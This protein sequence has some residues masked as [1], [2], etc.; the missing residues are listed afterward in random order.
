MSSDKPSVTHEEYE[1]LTKITQLVARQAEH[2]ASVKALREDISTIEH[3]VVPMLTSAA[4]SLNPGFLVQVTSTSKDAMDLG[5][6]FSLVSSKIP[7]DCNETEVTWHLKHSVLSE[8]EKP[9]TQYKFSEFY[10]GSASPLPIT[11]AQNLG[12]LYIQK[13]EAE[14]AKRALDSELRKT[15]ESNQRLLRTIIDRSGSQSVKIVTTLDGKN[16]VFNILK[17]QSRAKRGSDNTSDTWKG[18][19]KSLTAAVVEYFAQPTRSQHKFFEIIRA[20]QKPD[21]S[22]QTNSYTIRAMESADRTD[23]SKKR[24]KF[25]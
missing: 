13:T 3:S 9:K 10:E 25:T 22:V 17:I 20:A 19:M 21:T 24:V 23:G 1:T 6:L 18:P 8:F 5:E 16:R 11:T 14:T 15:L 12:K 4:Y 2:S 7:K